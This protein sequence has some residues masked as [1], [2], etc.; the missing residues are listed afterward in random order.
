M[1][2][3]SDRSPGASL[4]V[5]C[6][7]AQGSRPAPVRRESRVRSIA[8]G[9]S[10]ERLRPRKA[11]RSPVYDVCGRAHGREGHPI[12]IIGMVAIAGDHGLDFVVPGGH[13]VHLG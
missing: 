5:T 3:I 8:A 9:L 1:Q 2:V 13:D 4:R 12:R 10:I 7:A 11:V 6:N